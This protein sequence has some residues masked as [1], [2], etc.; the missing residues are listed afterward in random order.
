MDADCS[1]ISIENPY[2]ETIKTYGLSMPSARVIFSFII[3]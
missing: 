3:Q 2:W 1:K